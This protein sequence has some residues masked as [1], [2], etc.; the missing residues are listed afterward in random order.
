MT[1]PTA[2]P[3]WRRGAHDPGPSAPSQGAQPQGGGR[4]VRLGTD[5]L[6]IGIDARRVV[7]RGEEVR[8]TKTEWGLLETLCEHP[9]KLQTASLAAERVWA[10]G[11]SGDV[12]VL[13]VFISL[14][15]GKIEPDPARPTI[16][17]TDPGVGYR[18]LLRSMRRRVAARRGSQGGRN[19]G[20]SRSARTG[21]S[22]PGRNRGGS[23]VDARYA[24]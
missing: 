1:G 6:E 22:L 23:P 9:G 14:P 5:N 20:G 18:W 16:I 12:D 24:R 3:T 19:R 21:G 7:R 13:W 17:A 4:P 8:L 11:Y 15:R 10:H 2:I